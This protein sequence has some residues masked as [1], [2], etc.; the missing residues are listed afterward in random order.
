M[1][2]ETPIFVK[3]YDFSIWLFERT[4]HFPKR[5]RHSLTERI[6]RD[7]LA[8]ERTLIE[9]N[10]LRGSLRH[11]ALGRADTLLNALRLNLRRSRDLRCMAVKSYRHAACLLV[12][13]GRLLGGWQRLCNA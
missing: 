8:F 10:R 3:T 5:L 13:I 7:C 6:E 9:A 12:E 2:P 11:E 1:L 4:A